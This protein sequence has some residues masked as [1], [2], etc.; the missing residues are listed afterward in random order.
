MRR[1][2]HLHL[3]DALA[4]KG[5]VHQLRIQ[6]RSPDSGVGV[7]RAHLGVGGHD[8]DEEPAGDITAAEQVRS[9]SLGEAIVVQRREGEQLLVEEGL[10]PAVVVLIGVRHHRGVEADPLLQLAEPPRDE[11][12][13]VPALTSVDQ[14]HLLVR[15]GLG[16]H[17]QATV[18]LADVDEDDLKRAFVLAVLLADPISVRSPLHPGPTAGRFFFDVE[19]VPPEE[20]LDLLAP[21]VDV[22]EVDV[23]LLG[24]LNHPRLPPSLAKC[25]QATEPDL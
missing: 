11:V 13:H 7:Q 25:R 12:V 15:S 22:P 24:E 17:Q 18:A 19:E 14:D 1:G 20:L 6:L 2:Q 4:G 3:G 23:P 21:V 16:R 10:E 5:G 9:A 8:V